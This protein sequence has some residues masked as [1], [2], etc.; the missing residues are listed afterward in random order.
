MELKRPDG[1]FRDRKWDE[2]VGQMTYK[3]VQ[4]YEL[5]PIQPGSGIWKAIINSTIPT[6]QLKIKV[7][8]MLACF[9]E[10]AWFS[11]NYETGKIEIQKKQT[12][13]RNFSDNMLETDKLV[14]GHD[15]GDKDPAAVEHNQFDDQTVMDWEKF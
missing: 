13:L 2:L 15:C 14:Y 12:L 8:E 11:Y 10:T 5:L 3:H 9:N 7:P 1:T 6:S 4:N